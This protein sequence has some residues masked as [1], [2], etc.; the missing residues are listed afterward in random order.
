[1]SAFLLLI[2]SFCTTDSS[3]IREADLSFGRRQVEQIICDRPDMGEI[4]ERRPV[5]RQ[6]LELRFAGYSTGSRIYWDC[7]EPTSDRPGEHLISHADFPVMVRVSTKTESAV[8]KCAIL[9]FE[10]NNLQLDK[11]FQLLVTS[12]AAMKKSRDEFITSCVRHEFLASQ[13]TQLYFDTHPLVEENIESHPYYNSLVALSGDFS[14]YIRWLDQLDGETY[15]PRIYFGR[16][17]NY[18]SQSVTQRVDASE[19][20]TAA[21]KPN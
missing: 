2:A 5:F 13:K 20:A 4:I 15:D 1:M 16:V 9:L 19:Q 18:L 11:E 8:D 7:R 6:T 17:Y 14:D 12:P 21:A 3:A 10:L